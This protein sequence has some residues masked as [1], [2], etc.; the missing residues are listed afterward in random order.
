[1]LYFLLFLPKRTRCGL[2]WGERCFHVILFFAVTHLK[3][4]GVIL[5]QNILVST[6]FVVLYSGSCHNVQRN[7]RKRSG[8]LTSNEISHII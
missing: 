3:F 2:F 6:T 4:D 8:P 5:T 1:M 7:D